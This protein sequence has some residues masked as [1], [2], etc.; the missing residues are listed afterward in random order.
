MSLY[1]VSIIDWDLIQLQ[2]IVIFTETFYRIHQI[3][4]SLCYQII[5]RLN[6]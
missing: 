2:Q 3:H 5:I 6:L 4:L 1:V